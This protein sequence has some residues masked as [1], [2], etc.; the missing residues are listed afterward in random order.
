MK[1]NVVLI[2]FVLLGLLFL[3]SIPFISS[4]G[5]GGSDVNI[6]GFDSNQVKVS[7]N[8]TTAGYLNGK[9]VAG[10]NITLTENNDGGNETLTIS[11]TASGGGGGSG[12][13]YTS[14]TPATIQVNNDSNTISQNFDGNFTT[15]INALDL[16]NSLNYL[17]TS[18]DGN[19]SIL[20]TANQVSV[21]NGLSRLFRDSNVVLSLPQNIDST[22][23]PTFSELTLSLGSGSCFNINVGAQ[24]RFDVDCST[25]TTTSGTHL[26]NQAGIS[27]I[28]NSTNRWDDLWITDINAT[29]TNDFKT[30]CIGGDC[31]TSWPTSG[32]GDVTWS[33]LNTIIPWVDANV[34]N[35]IT[36]DNLTQITTRNY[37]DL[38]NLPTIPTDTN[39]STSADCN[40]MY[41]QKNPLSDQ[42][43]VNQ[44]L[45]IN[46]GQLV[47]NGT[48]ALGNGTGNTFEVW[49]ESGTRTTRLDQNGNLLIDGNFTC[50]DA[51]CFI[52]G[53]SQAVGR[54][55]FYNGYQYTANALTGG[56][57]LW[58]SANTYAFAVTGTATSGLYFDASAPRGFKFRI[59]GSDRFIFGS[60][61]TNTDGAV[62]QII[63]TASTTG[64]L[65]GTWSF[66]DI[67]RTDMNWQPYIR[68]N[69]IEN[70]VN[71]QVYLGT[72]KNLIYD[73]NWVGDINAQGNYRIDGNVTVDK[74][75]YGQLISAGNLVGVSC[76][77]TC[78]AYS[79]GGPWT[80]VEATNITGATST[81]TDVTVA[82]N[83]LCRN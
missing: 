7:S 16:N 24:Q 35:N 25:N 58:I 82:H 20:G 80:C 55:H 72:P 13:T 33:A 42:I 63:R 68:R 37:S 48:N 32:T 6:S 30:L 26:P 77:T 23:T 74:N 43:I 19:G 41:I 3:I 11:S 21:T 18:S 9:L 2:G 36:L 8:D 71:A 49:N 12:T 75:I 78:G 46:N 81:C 65:D 27:D 60:G 40:N 22:A 15:R 52:G 47:L 1:D 56:G 10:S 17:K 34:A 66:R 69:G 50:I 62:W 28:G 45:N 29:G 76:N 38:Q 5:N 64:M 4:S 67:G 73:A 14:G 83:C 39:C 53:T 57:N 59:D 31:K 51:N 61:S 79:Y 44:D 70:H 54:R